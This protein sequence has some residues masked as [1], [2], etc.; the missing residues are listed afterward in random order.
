MEDAT[1]WGYS[2]KKTVC[3]Y[4]V[5]CSLSSLGVC[6]I[7]VDV[8]KSSV[9]MVTMPNGGNNSCHGAEVK[10]EAMCSVCPCGALKAKQEQL[11]QAV[12]KK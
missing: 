11:A 2:S 5:N 3:T 8:N 7:R 6:Y 4:I 9:S 1:S 10:V 12:A